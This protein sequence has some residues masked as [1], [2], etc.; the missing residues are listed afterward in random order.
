MEESQKIL[1]AVWNGNLGIL[2]D[3]QMCYGIDWNLCVYD[4]T[5]DSALHIAARAGL[6]PIMKSAFICVFLKEFF[7]VSTHVLHLY[8]AGICTRKER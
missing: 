1:R 2:R 6:L 4:K 7:H 3:L 8:F 5:G